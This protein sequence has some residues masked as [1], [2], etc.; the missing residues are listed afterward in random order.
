[1]WLPFPSASVAVEGSAVRASVDFEVDIV[2]LVDYHE[3]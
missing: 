1:V 2:A 3:P